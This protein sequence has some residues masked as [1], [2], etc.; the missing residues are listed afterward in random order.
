MQLT[1]FDR[2]LRARFVYET[3][4]QTLS[5]PESLP[6]G[7]RFV[8][9]ADVPGK[10]YKHLFVAASEK[11]ANRFIEQLKENSQ[12][13]TTQVVDRDAWYVPFI[14]P[15][16]NRSL[17][18]WIFSVILVSIAAFFLLLYLKGL[19]QDPEFRANFAEALKILQG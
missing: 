19:V 10:R 3:H 7:V 1:R 2:W 8:E 13:Y 11:A 16:D 12:M 14:A 6:Q 4:I 15:K 17:S 9:Q 5:Y 18:W